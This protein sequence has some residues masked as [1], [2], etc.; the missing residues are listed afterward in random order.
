MK[1]ISSYNPISVFIYF[2]LTSFVAMFTMEPVVAMLSLLGAVLLFLIRN[3]F[4]DKKIHLYY[5]LLFFVTAFINPLFNHNGTTVLFVMNDNPITKEALIY[6]LVAATVLVS[7]LYWFRS[8]S[9]IMT[10]DKL[11]YIFG[12]ISPKIALIIS[13]ALRFVPLFR[14]QMK[15][16]RNAQKALGLF[17]DGNIVDK[18]RGEIRVLSVMLTWALENGIVTADSMAAR[19]Y[20]ERK[21]TAFSYFNF[22]FSDLIFTFASLILF[23]FTAFGLGSKAVYFEFY[24]SLFH[25]GFTVKTAVIYFSYALLVFLPSALEIQE[26]LKWKYLRSK[27]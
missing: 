22:G 27:I 24:P 19:G 16:T 23:I 13:G 9:I 26:G 10:S 15:K 1:N 12:L 17:K 7:V 2:I 11:I 8:F 21:R 4:S 18:I 3:G 25:N 5:A 14:V 20:G 6:G